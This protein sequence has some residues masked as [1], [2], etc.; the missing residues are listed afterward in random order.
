MKEKECFK[1]GE[2]K[3]LSQF[4][5]HSRMADGHLNKCKEC[6]KKDVA[7][8]YR[9][10][11]EYYREYE[12]ERSQRPERKA[13]QLEYQRE[14]RE[15][16]PLKYKAR[17]K[18]SNALRDGRIKRKPCEICGCEDAEAHHDDYSKP[19]QVRWLCFEHHRK[20][21]GQLVAV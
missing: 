3:P 21:H 10:N 5:A 16:N 2:T 17:N 9:D 12:K 1:C 20:E 11:I 8:N 19:L 14:R 13:K 7:K 6:T 18:V 4:Y 15:N